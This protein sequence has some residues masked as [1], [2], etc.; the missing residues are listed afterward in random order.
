MFVFHLAKGTHQKPFN[1]ENSFYETFD[2]LNNTK[3]KSNYGGTATLP[4][5]VEILSEATVTWI[6]RRDYSLL[7]GLLT[8]S[9]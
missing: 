2:T 4:C 7:T 1:V 5:E 9:G 8:I 3:I 6:R